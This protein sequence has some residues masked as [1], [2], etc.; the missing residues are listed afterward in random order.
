MVEFVNSPTFTFDVNNN[1]VLEHEEKKSSDNYVQEVFYIKNG[2]KLQE[3]GDNT[4][5][6]QVNTWQ[7]KKDFTLQDFFDKYADAKCIIFYTPTSETSGRCGTV[8]HV[9]NQIR[10]C[11]IDSA[12]A[13]IP[14]G[15]G[16]G[17]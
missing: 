12:E 11:V 8:F 3:L 14:M 4:R 2:E 1:V 17:C 16:K 6:M 10:G 9:G 15:S 7:L 13:P 5:F